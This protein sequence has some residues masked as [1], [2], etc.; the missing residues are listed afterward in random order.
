MN[1]HIQNTTHD[2]QA[3]DVHVDVAAAAESASDRLSPLK[4]AYLAL[5]QSQAKVAE[6]QRVRHE[7]I[8]IVGMACRLPGGANCPEAFW[9]LLRDAKDA[10]CEVPAQRWKIADWY[11]PD[12]EAPGKM[13]TRFGGF[14]REPIDQ[15]DPQLF[16]ISPREACCMD[17]QQRLLLEV[18]WE[19]L[20]NAAQL[21]DR[22]PGDSTGVFVGVTSHDYADSFFSL[23]QLQ[24]ANTYSITG[25]TLNGAAG[26]LSYT[27]GFQGPCLAIDTACSSSLVSVHLACQSLLSGEC[28]RAI[29]GGVNLILSPWSMVALSKGG[30][31]AA[32]GR[33]KT[34]DE[35]ADGMVR[36]E[37]CAMVVLK[38]LSQAVADGDNIL[39]LIRG[40][41]VN[42]D[43]PSSGLTVP[44]G[45]AQQALL[46][47]ALT[48][49]RLRP[50][51]IDYV[52]AHGTGTSLGDPVE[53]RALGNV[54]AG[55]T[56][57][58][59]AGSVK[60]NVGHLESCAGIA[61]LLKVVLC[62]Q[63]RQFPPQ[64]HF[65]Q[66]TSQVRWDQLPIS[67]P[68]TLSD[69]PD[70]SRPRRAG[71]SS[72][73][74]VGVNAHVILEESPV[75]MH[76][77]QVASSKS[78]HVA[79]DGRHGDRI[80]A[81]DRPLHVLSLSARSE[82]A[83]E[84]LA[85]R[86]EDHLADHPDLP[87]GDVCFS[88]NVGR[89]DMPHRCAVLADSIGGLREQL[90][91]LAAR[92]QSASVLRGRRDGPPK[93]A[94]LFSG[95]GSQYT[96]AGR[97]LLETQP[98]FRGV[99][100]Q[101]TDILR[102]HLERPL[103]EVLF[104][105]PGQPS[106]L[107]ETIYAQPA[108]FALEFALVELWRSWGIEPAVVMGHSLGEYVAACVAGVFS[109]EDGLKLVA[110]RA[111]LMQSVERDGAMYAVFADRPRVE[112]AIAP[113]RDDVSIAA[114][115]APQASVISG[116]R[117][118]V[119]AIL[120][121]LA[122]AGVKAKELQVSH[123]FHSPH[124]DPILPP[125]QREAAKIEFKPPRISLISNLT[126]APADER[127]RS[128]EYWAQ[129]ARQPVQFVEAVQAM[130][131]KGCTSFVEVG[132]GSVLLGLGRQCL[133]VE[134]ACWLP[135]LRR[136]QSDWRQML[137]SLANL[138]VRGAKVDW[139]AFDSDRRRRRVAL[140]TYPFQRKR[141]WIESTA[142]EPAAPSRSHHAAPGHPLL[143]RRL[144]LAG[145]SEVR[146]ESKIGASSAG[147]FQ[148]HRVF[149]N[150]VVPA[151]AYVEMALAAG[152]AAVG[153]ETIALKNI[154]FQQPLMLSDEAATTIQIVMRPTEAADFEF[155]IFSSSDEE[156]NDSGNWTRNAYGRIAQSD[157]TEIEP[158][159]LSARREEVDVEQLYRRCRE[160]GIDFGPRFQGLDRLWQCDGGGF[161]EIRLPTALHANLGNYH[162]HPVILDSAFQALNAVSTSD[163]DNDFDVYLP[164]ALDRLRLFRRAPAHCLC[165]VRVEQVRS[166]TEKSLTV[167]LRLVDAESN[168][169]AVIEG[170][171]LKR[172]SQE[173]VMRS[174][175]AALQDWLY[176]VE[177]QAQTRAERGDVTSHFPSGDAFRQEIFPRLAA[178]ITAL[179]GLANHRQ[180]MEQLESLS[181][182]YIAK[183]L[184]GLGC[185]FSPQDLWTTASLSEQLGIAPQYHRL[186]NRLLSVLAEEGIATKQQSRWQWVSKPDH[187]NPDARLD[188][189]LDR[190]PE[191]AAEITLVR[192]C[193]SALAEV[194]TGD[195]DPLSLLFPESNGLSAANAYHDS[196]GAH[197]SN[198]AVRGV[199]QALLADVP[200][201]RQLRVLE[202]GAGTGGA[203]AAILPE[204]S[205]RA[206]K[207]CFTDISP[208]FVNEAAKKFSAHSFVDYKVLDVERAFADQGL[209][210]QSFDL[211]IAANVLHATRDLR[212]TLQHAKQVLAP[213]GFLVLLE[214][215]A[216]LR[217]IDL[218]FG[219]TD[220]W[221]RFEDFDLRA[222][223]PLLSA[224]Q[225]ERLLE[226]CGFQWAIS[227]ACSGAAA[228]IFANQSVIVARVAE[229]DLTTT[230]E[231]GRHW[232]V[233]ADRS[234]VADQ[235]KGHFESQGD[236]CTLVFA[237]NQFDR[238]KGDGNEIAAFDRHELARIVGSA[239]T[240]SPRP[241]AGIVHLWNLDAAAADNSLT[242]AGLEA[243]LQLSCG[244]ALQLVQ[245]V[246]TAVDREPPPLW[247]VTQGAQ[248]VGRQDGLSGVAQSPL[249]GFG[250]VVGLEH[251]ELRC[252]RVDLD[253]HDRASAAQLLYDEI[254]GGTPED[255]VAFRRGERF[256]PR[257]AR[258]RSRPR[259]DA[260][261][262]S[263]DGLI[264][265]VGG[266][267]GLGLRVVRWMCEHGA[268]HVVLTGRREPSEAARQQ[269]AELERNGMAIEIALADVSDPVQ[270]SRLLAKISESALPL[271]GIIH[272]AGVLDDGILLQ[273]DWDRFRRV[274][275]PKIF[276]AWFL[277][278]Q[279][280]DMPLDFF[281]MFSSI[282]SLFGSVGQ[283][284][285]AAAN[286]FLDALAFH[287]RAGGLPALSINWGAWAEIGAAA[288]KGVGQ[289]IK[290]KG[291]GT[292]AVNQGLQ[293]M[294]QLMQDDPIQVGVAPIDWPL[295]AKQSAAGAKLPFFSQ[296]AE[297]WTVRDAP[298]ADDPRQLSAE[299]RGLSGEE[300]RLRVGRFVRDQVASVLRLAPD[301][302]DIGEPLNRM[303]LDSLMA[304]ELRN[305][306]RNALE[307]DVP[308]VKFMED[309]S[310]TDLATQISHQLAASQTRRDE[311][312]TGAHEEP[313]P[314]EHQDKPSTQGIDPHRAEQMLAE[315]DQ[316]TDEQ[317]DA[318]LNAALADSGSNCHEP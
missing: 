179:P 233:L 127:I 86:F 175:S 288:R 227:P 109:L 30:V 238:T 304:V 128:A 157:E 38:R 82:T 64:L 11:D 261:Q 301:E 100:E 79:M 184:L 88:A 9:R 275:A 181:V 106:P 133:D 241:L 250:R 55:R 146:F 210:S 41:A 40:S 239:M 122:A 198:V 162:L 111:S 213:G 132:P 171:Q 108:L 200:P 283:A 282:A 19:A 112:E 43:G 115:N 258:H 318:L 169:V 155:E 251:P 277:H 243:A 317:V 246:A 113:Y 224:A 311:P 279:T 211:V 5:E 197:A 101:C 206:A 173:A 192:R 89:I 226:D 31:L 166:A 289:R 168:P 16:G 26:R 15:F 315:F 186:I 291:M 70:N 266:L 33:C 177:W 141:Y 274:L 57:P 139:A 310:I 225:W 156:G 17:P 131:N 21:P 28:H 212:Q 2:S 297:Q 178:T 232:I 67:I 58:L 298:P 183:A 85:A 302:V 242:P 52:E 77:G 164:V 216:P 201:D 268:R 313:A 47:R 312:T 66:P 118:V 61:G 117:Q 137:E 299:L 42:Q 151:A 14:L 3:P 237:S 285:H 176:E 278:T 187:S 159:E 254:L 36:G 295:F 25:N 114:L 20:E 126:G 130:Q 260:L 296:F 281:V 1:R 149:D 271:R 65:K 54:F 124:M 56:T 129:H 97:E 208:L 219:L 230:G 207:Y 83:L 316:L 84:Q 69:W 190:Y 105:Q 32:D 292:I 185:D 44:N 119:E 286:A 123:A 287:R 267:G 103:L 145:T 252:V 27:F 222:D 81:I 172:T 188:V 196:P 135:S 202:V 247:L 148:D 140:P 147:F 214:G 249:W 259:H 248:P 63:H 92:R 62:L 18:S 189:L 253:P 120:A 80:P 50:D 218:T 294:E 228:D 73:G 53:L 174:T 194:L 305:R 90:A 121:E 220:G 48:V 142:R 160:R 167:D 191:S 205:G 8:A 290:H 125:L 35:S 265:I 209:E 93:I 23:D 314:L 95:Q 153:S 161:G 134:A 223:H 199:V 76:D 29:A 229:T 170:L 263:A 94:F 215:T 154:V 245:A 71:V 193:G 116:T 110:N 235:L 255:Q 303:G 96:G 39:A 104:P 6:L 262:L 102:G 150:V 12:P 307:L 59:C 180:V 221:W 273:Q 163:D 107:D 195:C 51:E 309:V 24:H 240:V 60:A 99:L 256:V 308:I 152:A 272:A 37:G 138:Y 236:D 280:Q 204:L 144:N 68:T 7:P 231:F 98:C 284:N 234:G 264:L 244:V 22:L 257:L 46:Q 306:L 74:I 75:E 293:L 10:I 13:C 269:L 49:A 136:G 270:V 165:D 34:F 4:R 182:D 87:I 276:G 217:F 203:T 45:P 91:S 78:R 300:R 72:F 143:A 158:T